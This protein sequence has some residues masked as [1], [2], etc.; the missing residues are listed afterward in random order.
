MFVLNLLFY[1]FITI[2]FPFNFFPASIV[3]DGF[4]ALRAPHASQAWYDKFIFPSFREYF[5]GRIR[6][7]GSS[8]APMSDFDVDFL[9]VYLNA[10]FLEFYGTTETTG[11]ICAT[12]FHKHDRG[13]VGIP[14]RGVQVCLSDVPDMDYSTRDSPHA[15]GQICVRGPVVFRG[16]YKDPEHTREVLTDDGWFLTDDI[17]MWI[18]GAY[19]EDVAH[20]QLRRFHGR[21]FASTSASASPSFDLRRELGLSTPPNPSSSH[22]SSSSTSTSP[23]SPFPPHPHPP[24]SIPPAFSSYTSSSTSS[25][26]PASITPSSTPHSSTTS[27]AHEQNPLPISEGGL[28]PGFPFSLRII[29]RKKNVFKLAQGEFVFA[30][31]LER[32]FVM[33]LSTQFKY[34][35]F[36]LI[37]LQLLVHTSIVRLFV[38]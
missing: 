20:E 21:M 34:S 32:F 4:S 30:D 18:P 12:Q 16:Y 27:P 1:S 33:F 37:L 26:P 15:R 6:L 2:H 31:R 5:G 13:N 17:G 28:W 35:S 29:D 9:S 36:S 23:T 7:F 14:V 19:D 22:S 25:S 3:Q 8:T 11:V 38:I 24:A 10:P